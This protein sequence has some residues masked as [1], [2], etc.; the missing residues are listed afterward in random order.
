VTT[1]DLR[2]SY[3]RVAAEYAARIFDELTH[4]PLDRALLD[5]F[6]ERVRG[7]GPVCDLG[8]G[9]GHVARYLHERGV[10]MFGVDLSPGMVAQAQQLNPGI[11][12]YQGDMLALNVPDGTWAGI[13][14][15]Y[16][17]I[18]VPHEQ[19]VPALRELW[20]VLQPGGLLLTAFHLG[21]DET[22]HAD[23]WWGQPV[24]LDFLFF[25]REAMEGYLQAAD[26]V[27]EAVVER[28]PYPDVEHQSHRA[29]MLARKASDGH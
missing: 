17:L 2:D 3:D 20:R 16:C 21:E 29:Y 15:F 11:S 8:C 23:E 10:D 9:P 18:H 7:A 13:V 25:R 24:S 14:A 28:P 6:A 22:I 1:A 19:M 26:F 5:R 12:F 27:I 4:K